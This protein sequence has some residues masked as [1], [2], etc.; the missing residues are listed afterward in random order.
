MVVEINKNRR[1]QLTIFIILAI[2]IVVGIILFFVLRGRYSVQTRETLG[3]EGEIEK[4]VGD[5]VGESVE[6]VLRGGGLIEPELLIMYKDEKY[7]YLCY[8]LNYYKGCVNQYPLLNR[9]VVEQ[10]MEDSELEVKRCLSNVERDL[11]AKGWS[12][13]SG[14]FGWNVEVVPGRVLVS[15]EKKMDIRKGES[16]QSFEKF[17]AQVLSPLH[18]LVLLAHEIVNQESQYCHFEYVGFMLLY[19]DYDIKRIDYTDS[20]IY[21]L[22]DR[23]S[24]KVFKFAVRSCALPP[25][26]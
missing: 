18:G 19:P 23:R 3:I 14:G 15:I 4:C 5:V 1:G 8:Q 2:V 13:S 16:S 26:M 12:V 17:D 25:G 6:K 10:I 24:G 9:I 22:E 20:K 11:E 7:N 21:I